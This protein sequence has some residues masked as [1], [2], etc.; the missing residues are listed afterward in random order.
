MIRQTSPRSRR[1][2]RRGTTGLI[3]GAAIAALAVLAS[4]FIVAPSSLAQ[5]KGGPAEG[6]APQMTPE[7]MQQMM[8]LIQPGERHQGMARNV[9][10][11]KTTMKMWEGPGDPIVQ[12]GTMSCEMVLGGRYLISRHRAE[13][14]GMPFEGMGIDAYDNAKKQYVSL[15]LD[16]FGT[17]VMQLT[18][19]PAKDGNGVDY[20]GTMYDPM[21]QADS[22][23]REEFRYPDADH[24]VMTMY[25]AA[26]DGSGEVKVMELAGVRAK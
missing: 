16:N 12:E 20:V 4:S 6:G 5:D 19:Q 1:R 7:Q 21:R 3:A 8:A 10:E 9:G 24:F 17:G 22:R 13:Y 18:G 23:V 25:Q 26:P 15:W 14:R 2:A 11:W